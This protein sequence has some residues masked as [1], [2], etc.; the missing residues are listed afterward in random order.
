MNIPLAAQRGSH[1]PI[2][3]TAPGAF[4]TE[5]PPATQ[6]VCVA[7]RLAFAALMCVAP[8][9]EVCAATAP[10]LGTTGTYGVLSSTFTNSNTSPQTII[11]GDVCYTTGPTTAPLLITGATST[12][13]L[14]ATGLDQTAALATLNGEPCT[15]LGAGAI[16]LDALVVGG[17]PPGVIPPGCYS[18]GDAMNITASTTVTLS[19]AGVY[20]FRPTGALT[21]GQDSTVILAAGACASDV[22]WAPG[23]AV[24]LGANTAASATPTFVG[25]ILDAAG[26]TIGH[27]ANMTGRALAYGA[28]VTTDAV[29]ITVPT[30]APIGNRAGASVPTL[31]GQTFLALVALMGLLGVA[32]FRRRKI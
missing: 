3:R 1:A 14:A 26:I 18:N 9:S 5:A 4:P 27:F 2:P 29:T 22:Y 24:T 23:G 17:N 7:A 28:T 6:G 15:F 19:G 25:N 10:A 30:C 20:V 32:V 11:N 21:T 8:L 12:P 13:C 31:S 16:A